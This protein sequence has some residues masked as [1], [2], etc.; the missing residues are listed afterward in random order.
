MI[1][2][3]TPSRVVFADRMGPV[4][5][6]RLL[7]LRRAIRAIW[8]FDAASPV[9]LRLI[10]WSR[11]LGLIRAE[12]RQVEHNIGH[13]R[14]DSGKFEWSRLWG[15]IRDTGMKISKE[16]T[17][18]D[19]LVRRMASTW[20]PAKVATYFE[21]KIEYELKDDCYRIGLVEWLAR[22]H[23]GVEPSDC[24]LVLERG[25]WYPYIRNLA[26]SRGMATA[27]YLDPW[28]VLA[29]AIHVVFKAA[30]RGLLL[31]GGLARGVLR[32]ARFTGA[33]RRQSK[34]AEAGQ[35][36]HAPAIGVRY[37]F[38][39]LSLD[40]SVRSEFFWLKDSN[41]PY[42]NVLIYD[43][44]TDKPLD[45]ETASRLR[46]H[47][48][49]LIGRGPGVPMWRPTRRMY[50]VLLRVMTRLARGLLACW[51]RG[52]WVSPYHLRQLAV[53]A[54]DYSY[55]YDFYRANG[56]RV[57]VSA[58][59]NL[60]VS[61]VLALDDLNGVSAV[62]QYASSIIC[63]AAS[64]LYAGEDIVFVFSPA[65][66]K[67]WHQIHAPVHSIVPVG[68]VDDGAVRHLRTLG[69]SDELRGDLQ[70]H[71]ARFVLSYFD[72]NSTDRWNNYCS[73]EQSATDYEF[74]L[75]WL[76]ADPSLGIVFKPKKATNLLLRIH[77]VKGLVDEAMATGR[78]RFLMG[79]T[80]IGGIFPAEAALAS[81]VCIGRPATATLESRLAGVPSL[82]I[83]LDGFR[84]DIYHS[85]GRGTTVFDDWPS[86][87]EAVERYRAD[88]EGYPEL[89][90]WSPGIHKIDPF[91]DGNASLRIGLY[92]GLVFEALKGGAG[93]G[94]ALSE[95]AEKYA[96]GARSLV[97][98]G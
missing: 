19:P 85:W 93:K 25:Q 65:F 86:L 6:I 30:D 53:L 49:R 63:L 72:E 58:M 35:K 57:N 27:S 83:D 21:K 82:M 55:W 17:L 88:P 20:E 77:R 90:D 80:V 45:A 8:Y 15:Y 75:R 36:A 94:E 59:H 32:M 44:V 3:A 12:V 22:S 46:E 76:L 23:L 42:S 48:I 74:L 28:G 60:K 54:L 11:R 16:R 66:E 95:A 29:K 43:Y 91:R 68:F 47:G 18:T 73:D 38:R 50:P 64:Y 67:L 33:P 89:G 62:Y 79:D 87:R 14:D 1:A 24:V 40:A 71:G 56:I 9:M 4:V 2:R 52:E 26:R 96:A 51:A 81:D 61:Q 69:R 78:C 97:R 39:S 31:V 41:I 10:S 70:S 98:T 92:V 7:G 13:V 34:A 84:D 37:Y 5:L